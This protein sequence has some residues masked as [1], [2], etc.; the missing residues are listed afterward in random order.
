MTNLFNLDISEI[1]YNRNKVLLIKLSDNVIYEDKRSYVIEYTVDNFASGYLDDIFTDD[2]GSEW[3]IG[4][5]K[6]Y[7]LQYTQGSYYYEKLRI[8]KTNGV[9]TEDPHIELREISKVILWFPSYAY[10]IRFYGGVETGKQCAVKTIEYCDTSEF[11]ET[12]YMF[13][14]CINLT[15]INCNEWNTSKLS[16]MHYMFYQC[17]YLTELDLSD[18]DTSN[19]DDMGHMFQDC[20]NLTSVNMN[21]WDTSDCQN[22]NNMFSGCE[23]LTTLIG[24]ENFAMNGPNKES[25]GVNGVGDTSYM[26]N[27]CKSLTELDLSNWKI[28]NIK[29]MDSMF[30]TCESL[31]T[32]GNI[33][34][35]NVSN[36]TNMNYMF[37]YCKSLTELDLSNWIAN[38]T[39]C[40]NMFSNCT[41]LVTLDVSNLDMH[42]VSSASWMF[43]RCNEL[44][45]LKPPKNINCELNLRYSTKLTHD[46]LM[47][48]LRNL[49]TVTSS[50]TLT[51]GTDN[52]AKLTAAE[53]S[54][55]TN[56]GW[57]LA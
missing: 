23:K 28:N 11:K 2:S 7:T 37:A 13:G 16:N 50:K 39:N 18:F 35:W 43:Y 42:G 22:M 8:I 55:A 9:I 44:V 24:I 3:Y 17:T 14:N 4:I 20:V 6:I 56:K 45:N 27:N 57:T 19:V 26:F 48:I 34:N 49:V 38:L 15:S 54:I 46:S 41:S 40:N 10:G 53:K 33:N 47:S 1:R 36:V 21:N 25:T 30:Y 31:I 32:I 5:P 12:V 29:Y 52:L 51:L